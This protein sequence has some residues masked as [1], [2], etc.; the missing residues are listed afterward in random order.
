[1]ADWEA[2]PDQ[3]DTKEESTAPTFRRRRRRDRRRAGST[4]NGGTRVLDVYG[5]VTGNGTAV[6]TELVEASVRDA[7]S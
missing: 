5:T 1:V 4:S 7:L 6:D 3:P 2:M